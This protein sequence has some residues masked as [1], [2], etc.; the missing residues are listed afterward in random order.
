[1][2]VSLYEYIHLKYNINKTYTVIS[3]TVEIK[4]KL[5]NQ[6]T[7]II[8]ES[9][10]IGQLHRGDVIK[11]VATSIINNQIWIYIGLD[12]KHREQWC[13]AKEE[14]VVYVE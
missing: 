9:P 11:C 13:C 7:D 14:G 6:D 12:E 10:T 2:T 5:P 1:M 3:N 8:P 4:T